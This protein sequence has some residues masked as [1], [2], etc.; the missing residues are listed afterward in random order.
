[1][2]RESPE[3]FIAE[4]VLGTP[5]EKGS[6]V[7]CSLKTAQPNDVKVKSAADEGLLRAIRAVGREWNSSA[8]DSLYPASFAAERELYHYAPEGLENPSPRRLGASY[9]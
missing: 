8:R 3:D 4:E 9:E 5:L 7:S 6:C 1:M 2:S